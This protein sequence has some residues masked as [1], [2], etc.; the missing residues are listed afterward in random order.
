MLQRSVCLKIRSCV[1]AC[2][3]LC[4]CVC[5]C[6]CVCGFSL[7]DSASC[8]YVSYF[9]DFLHNSGLF[10]CPLLSDPLGDGHPGPAGPKATNQ[11]EAGAT[12]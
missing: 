2:V 1:R 5:V 12:F 8:L 10:T 3:C 4:A 6:V 7:C 9:V 11:T